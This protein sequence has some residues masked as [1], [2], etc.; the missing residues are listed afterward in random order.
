MGEEDN[1]TENTVK[2]EE[3][4]CVGWKVGFAI[5]VVLSVI[6]FILCIVIYVKRNSIH[7][8]VDKKIEKYANKVSEHARNSYGRL[9]SRKS[10]KGGF[11][12]E[13]TGGIYELS[14]IVSSVKRDY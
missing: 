2:C 9:G 12:D 8:A 1:N 10:S 6:M 7:E 5:F 13:L 3:C 14:P 4:K 11:E